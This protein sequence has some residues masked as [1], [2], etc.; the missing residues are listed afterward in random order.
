MTDNNVTQ[1]KPSE[2]ASPLRVSREELGRF[3]WTFLHS[4][5]AAYPEEPTEKQKQHLLDFFHSM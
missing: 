4:I 5:A 2:D 3:T 1:I